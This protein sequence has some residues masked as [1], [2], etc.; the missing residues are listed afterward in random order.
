MPARLGEWLRAERYLP[1]PPRT[2]NLG[3]RHDDRIL[4]FAIVFDAPVSGAR[5]WQGLESLIAQSGD[6]LLRV[7]GIVNVTGQDQPRVLHIVQHVLYPVITLAS[8]PSEDRRTRLVF[9]VRD[10]AQETVRAVIEKAMTED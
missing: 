10:L 1:L 3:A 4:S 2:S 9:I 7:K 8:W 6:K 5:L